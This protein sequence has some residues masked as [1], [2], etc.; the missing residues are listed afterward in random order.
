MIEIKEIPFTSTY[1]VRHPVLRQ[2][3]PIES[4]FFDG[5]DL[6]TTKHFGAFSNEKLTGVVS[7]Y[8]NKNTNFQEN[9]PFQIR[10]MAVLTD[11]QKKGIGELLVLQTEDYVR[12]QNG[13]LIWFNARELAVGFYEKLNYQKMG[14]PFLIPD[15][16]LHYI[17]FKK[18]V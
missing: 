16:G 5:D 8:Q 10:G 17:M 1:S 6:P 7:V 15:I 2:G 4:C 3:K 18:L 14:E 9:N 13:E 11:F 12:K